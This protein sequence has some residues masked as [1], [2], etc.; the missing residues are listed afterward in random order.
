M[1]ALGRNDPGALDSAA[2]PGEAAHAG[3]LPAGALLAGAPGQDAPADSWLAKAWHRDW[4]LRQALCILE[5]FRPTL[6]EQGRF[7]ELDDHGRAMPTGCPPAPRPQQNLLTVTRAVHSF[8]LGELLGIPGCADVVDAGLAA[9]WEEHRDPVVGG[10]VSST[11]PDGVA[12]ATRSAYGH[13]FV[14]LAASTAQVAGHRQA[15]RLFEDAMEVIDTH[16]W[17]E[18]EGAAAEAFDGEWR[19]IEAYRG[20]NSNMHLCEALLAA[21]EAGARADL[22]GRAGLIA[23]RLIDGEARRNGWL[24][25]EHY[26]KSWQRMLDYNSDRLD[27]PFRPYG[28]TVGHSLEWSRL[29]ISVGIATG[30]LSG[31]WFL[32][33]AES[34]FE[35]AVAVGW[36]RRHGGLAYTVDWDGASA[37]P[38]HYW[39]PVAEGIG[40]ASYLLRLTGD[41]R[42]EEWYRRF[43][44]YASAV[45]IDH[46]RGGWHPMF[47]ARNRHKVHPWY[48]KP[49]MYHSLQACLLPLLP[50]APSLAGAVITGGQ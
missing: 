23:A 26:D 43:W 11:R 12:D 49:D 37:N 27:D 36:D 15:T 21:A 31:G 40:A 20:A 1:T 34:L 45:L 10:Y 7:V 22:A 44:D 39:W 35:R 29:V 47:D 50:L 5:F 6:S 25:P 24:L 9:L 18:E 42:Y 33:A 38:D 46:E 2:P 14:L 48:G 17:S 41:R 30:D 19:E 28:A 16:F 8:A 32:P 3:A 13:A 4:A